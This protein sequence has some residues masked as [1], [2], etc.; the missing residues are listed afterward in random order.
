MTA[1]LRP[2]TPAFLPLPCTPQEV[3]HPTYVLEVLTSGAPE[4][5]PVPGW[6]LRAWP[7]ARLGDLTVQATPQDPAESGPAA[8]RAALAAAGV[9]PLGPVRL[10]Q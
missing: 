7:V 3:C 4:L 2:T 10:H 9:T 8:L 6:T 1:S 5:P